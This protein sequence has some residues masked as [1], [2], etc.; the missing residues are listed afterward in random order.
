MGLFAKAQERRKQIA[1][2]NLEEEI[3]QY[4]LAANCDQDTA[5]TSFYDDLVGKRGLD[6]ATVI[7]LLQIALYIWQWFQ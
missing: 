1:A 2:D 5:Y 3:K 4:F 7:T 6:I